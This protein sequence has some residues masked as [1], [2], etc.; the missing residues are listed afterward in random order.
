MVSSRKCEAAACT[1]MATYRCDEGHFLCLWHTM[2]IAGSYTRRCILCM[3]RGQHSRA[4]G[5]SS[6]RI[7]N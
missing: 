4:E 7:A 3:D 6:F 5:L 1:E 2:R